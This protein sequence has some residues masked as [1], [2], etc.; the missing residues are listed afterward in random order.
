M[1]VSAPRDQTNRAVRFQGNTVRLAGRLWFI[2]L[3]VASLPPT[4]HTHR[5]TCSPSFDS[6]VFA[7]SSSH[8]H[9]VSRLVPRV[10]AVAGARTRR[11][12]GGGGARDYMPTSDG[13]RT[14]NSS[15]IPV[16]LSTS[17]GHVLDGVSTPSNKVQGMT[18]RFSKV[19]TLDIRSSSPP[20]S[21]S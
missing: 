13:S 1:V 12:R 21:R 5:L 10:I 19:R 16:K 18:P 17:T 15:S 3:Y 2:S 6:G 20:C 4:S 8:S 14:L 11:W 7:V 9:A